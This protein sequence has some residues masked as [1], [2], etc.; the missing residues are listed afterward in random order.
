MRHRKHTQRRWVGGFGFAVLVS[1]S[2]VYVVPACTPQ[3]DISLT[4]LERVQ[5][6]GTLVVLTRRSPTT[7]FETADGPRG[8]EYDLANAFAQSLGVRA[9]FVAIDRHA[10]LLRDLEA[11][12]ADLAAAG[13]VATADIADRF[14]FSPAYQK[15]QQQVVYRLGSTPPRQISDLIGRHIE[16]HRDTNHAARLRE[17]KQ[18]YPRLGWS[19]V[20]DNETEALLEMVWHGQLDVTLANSDTIALNRQLFPELQVAFDISAPQPLA[21]AFV[22][23]EDRSLYD[24]AVQFLHRYRSAGELARLVDRYFGPA[25]RAGDVNA[26]VYH[27]R[28][29]ERLPVFRALFARAG[30]IV[31]LDWRLLAAVAYQESHWDPAS[32]SPTGVRG[33]MMLTEDTAKYVGVTDLHDPEQ[34]ILGGARYLR[35][36]YDRLDYIPLPDRLWFALAAYNIGSG[37]LEDARILAQRHGKDPNSWSVIKEYLP[38]LEQPHWY[39]RTLFGFARGNETVSFV[40]RVRAYHDILLKLDQSGRF[41]PDRLRLKVPAI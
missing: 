21:W 35:D 11:G 12:Q 37:H 29:R 24:A 39:D 20:D 13:I 5:S 33:I 10:D 34:S 27:S 4:R 38:L 14:L 41:A 17:L 25:S 30:E 18:T 9:R 6:T 32:V 36:L 31:A 1:V 7:Y 3:K 19:E 40:N 16:V 26:Q 23:S 28:I 8:F 15:I 2:V 22:K